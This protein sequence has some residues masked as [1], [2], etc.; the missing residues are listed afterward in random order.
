ME[1]SDTDDEDLTVPAKRA[2]RHSS[3]QVVAEESSE[4]EEL[5]APVRKKVNSSAA[6]AQNTLKLASATRQLSLSVEDAPDFFGN[7]SEK[8]SANKLV[9]VKQPPTD[10]N[11]AALITVP[12]QRANTVAPLAED[13][14][15]NVDAE[16]DVGEKPFFLGKGINPK[17]DILL[18]LGVRSI[19]SVISRYSVG[20]TTR[21][22]CRLVQLN[23]SGHIRLM[24]SSS[25][26][27]YTRP[28][29]VAFSGTIWVWER[30]CK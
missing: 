6:T 27:I 24:A 13:I 8:G 4:D 26:M 29:L 15:G 25:C 7:F 17:R 11:T 16:I 23:G 22:Y 30:L 21:Q 14:V 10:D 12:V 19:A 3:P 2:V 28:K 18:G 20:R 1:D 5:S 9:K